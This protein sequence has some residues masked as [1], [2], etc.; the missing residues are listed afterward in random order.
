MALT[1]GI[2]SAVAG[3]SAYEAVKERAQQHLHPHA[4]GNT[5]TQSEF[6]VLPNRQHTAVYGPCVSYG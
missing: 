2:G 4:S 5:A 1:E 6:E 3:D